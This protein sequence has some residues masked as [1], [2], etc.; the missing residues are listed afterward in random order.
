[1][2]AWRPGGGLSVGP[3]GV[4]AR[5]RNVV[6][7]N[8]TAV[9]LIRREGG[10]GALFYCDAPYLHEP[11]TARRA[12]GPFEMTEADQADLLAVL[13]GCKGK[14]MLSGYPSRL[15]AEAPAGW[16]CHTLDVPNQ[17]SGAKVKGLETECLWC[18]F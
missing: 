4:A 6:L 11:R 16:T 2:A 1:L 15:Y 9:D 17:A 7:E 5:L 18:N 8:L 12:Y 10:P 13:R 14:V 3:Q